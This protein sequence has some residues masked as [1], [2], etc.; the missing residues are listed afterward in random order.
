MF[1]YSLSGGLP[2]GSRTVWS[3]LS[4][5]PLTAQPLTP[6]SYSILEEVAKSAWY[7]YFDELGFSPMPRARVVRQHGG[8]A[9][10]NL[11][12]SAQR[13]A[14]QA[15]VEPMAFAI[16][17]QPVPVA[18]WEKP[19][20]FAGMAS[21]RNRKKIQ[22]L[23]ARYKQQTPAITQQ[24]AVWYTKTQD[25]RWTQ[26]DILQ[27][28]EE[29]ERVSIPSFKLFFAA[30][31]N[32]EQI[33]NRLLWVTNPTCPFPANA[34]LIQKAL[35]DLSGLCEYQMAE[36][37]LQLGES[38][39]VDRATVA[40]L[41]AGNYAHWQETFP[42]PTLRMAIETFLHQYGHRSVAEAEVRQPRL[43]EDPATLFASLLAVV[44]KQPKLPPE[45]SVTPPMQQLLAAVAPDQQKGLQPQ[46]QQMHQLLLLQSQALHAFAYL[47]AGT[48]R[49][50]LAAAKEALGDQRLE[51]IEDVYFFQLEEVKQMMTGEWNIS[52]Q[53]E[54]RNTCK[55]RKLE[56]AA[57]QQ[58]TPPSMLIG[59]APMFP[60]HQGI[61]GVDGQVTAPL[62]CWDA[63]AA[64]SGA[65]GIVGTPHLDS[66]WALMLPVASAFITACGTPLDPIIAAAHAWHVPTVLALGDHYHRLVEGV[67]TTVY[68]E[69][70]EVVQ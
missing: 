4:L 41:Q 8:R 51:C 68:G 37:I 34:R 61:P 47:L 63:P 57:W 69:S 27:I 31:H 50:A 15:A 18:P 14:E 48:Q 44:Q 36:Q 19:G 66:G 2:A 49:W 16:N 38:A 65:E 1:A 28:M 9:Y 13:D 53:Q 32:L 60:V 45:T 58:D 7:Q 12:I 17:G 30:R 43:R 40:W 23:L 55:Q 42:N 22:Q 11:T 21:S 25:L 67:Q 35:A 52:S 3:Q 46:L 70:G 24:A 20:F 39:R 29:V 62:H 6:F 10:L 59:D 64:A 56:F 5:Q 33:Y 26:A 54:I